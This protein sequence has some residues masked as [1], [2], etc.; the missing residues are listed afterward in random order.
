[1]SGYATQ[2]AAILVVNILTAA[3]M[4]I[5]CVQLDLGISGFMTIGA[6][7]SAVLRGHD[8]PTGL[9]AGGCS[10][11]QSAGKVFQLDKPR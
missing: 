1:M 11:G 2:I 4:P 8:V 7:T 5:A 9:W 3:F 10:E 6:Y